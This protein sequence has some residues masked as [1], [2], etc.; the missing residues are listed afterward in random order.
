MDKT[1]TQQEVMEVMAFHEAKERRLQELY[2]E[3]EKENLTEEAKAK[4]LIHIKAVKRMDYQTFKMSKPE[5][6]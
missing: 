5:M 4:I 6:K 2:K 1:T 3:L